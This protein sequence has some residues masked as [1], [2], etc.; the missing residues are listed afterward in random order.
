M[1][2]IIHSKND[3]VE[4]LL[5]GSLVETM[6]SAPRILCLHTVYTSG[7]GEESEPMDVRI[8]RTGEVSAEKAKDELYQL[9][10]SRI[11]DYPIATD[12]SVIRDENAGVFLRIAARLGGM[13]SLI[14]TVRRGF[15]PEEWT[16]AEVPFDVMDTE[17]LPHFDGI[18]AKQW[19]VIHDLQ[20]ED[21]KSYYT[22]VKNFFMGKG[23]ERRI[24]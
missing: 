6:P 23:K 10:L 3:V 1:S 2:R 13:R 19:G 12:V 17:K 16:E 24:K 18:G 5:S 21:R 15:L 9:F 8:Y 4:E 20:Y 7:W 14:A 11:S 22:C